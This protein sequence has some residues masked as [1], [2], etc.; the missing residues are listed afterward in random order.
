MCVWRERDRERERE[1]ERIQWKEYR[2]KTKIYDYLL[3]RLRV[4]CPAWTL[5]VK[6]LAGGLPLME[7]VV[8]LK[9]E[10]EVNP[11]AAGRG[12]DASYPW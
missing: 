6:C 1:R 11:L 8:V 3:G 5:A 2:N 4:L 10:S 12:E 7:V 9:M